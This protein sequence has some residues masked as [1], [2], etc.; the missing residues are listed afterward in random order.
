MDETATRGVIWRERGYP[1]QRWRRLFV[2]TVAQADALAP[3]GR[4][5]V[6]RV[7]RVLW[8]PGRA[9][10]IDTGSPIDAVQVL[11]NLIGWR[12]VWGVRVL[13]ESGRYRPRRLVYG[14]ERR[15]PADA[16]VCGREIA[17]G[18]AQG[19]RP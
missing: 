7:I 13:A 19:H 17:E 18:L 8:P 6:V 3:D 12:V 15:L 9:V 5:Y 16:V 10:G 1:R 4:R 14:E 2:R 11:P